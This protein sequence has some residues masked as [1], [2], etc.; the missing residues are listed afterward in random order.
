MKFFPLRMAMRELRRGKR[1]FIFFVLC[2]AIGVAGLV[3]VKGFNASIQEAMLQ[4]ARPLMAADMTL[5]TGRTITPEQDQF[6]AATAAERGIQV[7]RVTE[8]TSMALTADKQSFRLVEV[9]AVELGYPFY[10]N[11]EVEPPGARLT[12]DTAWVGADLLDQLGLQVG[13]Q[14]SVGRA[15]FTISGLIL[16][17]PDRVTAGFSMGPRVMITAGG[18]AKA[19]LIQLGSRARFKYLFKLADDTQVEQLRADLK[20]AFKEQRPSIADFREANPQVKRFL[21]RMTDFLSLV[22]LVALLVGGLGVANATRAFLQQKLDSIAIMKCVGGTNRKILLIYLTQMLLLSL[23]GSALGVLLGYT[24]QLVM[25]QVVGPIVNLTIELHLQPIVALQGLA[26]GLVTSV[27]FTLLPLSAIADI[28]PGLV[29]RREMAE[30]RPAP[31]AARRIRTAALLGAIGLGLVLV[32]AWMS[33]SLKWGLWFM[34]GLAGSVLLLLGAAWLVVRSLKLIRVPRAWISVR[35]GLAS[36]YRPGSQA[37]AIVL[38]LGIGI[39]MVLAVYLLQKGL[40]NEVSITVPKGAPNMVFINLQ[41]PDAEAFHA[42]LQQHPGVA[43]A[44]APTAIV[45]G[46]LVTIDGKTRDEMNLSEEEARWFNFQ[47]QTTYTRAIPEGDIVIEGPWWTEA[48]W[49]KEPLVSIEREA[50]ERLHMTVGSVVEMDLEGGTPI[51]ARVFNIRKTTDY[52]AGGG[53]NFVFAPGVLEQNG[54]ITY[55]AQASVR[56][57][58]SRDVQRAVVARF[59]G[60]T[61]I[62]VA[63]MLATVTEM[64]DRI[65]LVIRFVAGFSVLAGLLILASSIATTKYRRTREAVLYKTL[66]ATRARV[67]RIF[68]VEYAAL[69]LIAGFVSAFLAAVATW[70]VMKY[71]MEIDYV[72]DVRSLAVGVLISLVLTIAVGVLSTIDVLAAKP[73]QVLREE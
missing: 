43:K 2:I 68:A 33:G 59:P 16:K 25:P 67:W 38:A 57:G 70:G 18:L 23:A 22:S 51:R 47:F 41:A 30:S 53:F 6:I 11:L 26:V 9:K 31:T 62:D 50:A 54:R 13:D 58:A 34:G 65:S 71:V 37:G 1:K 56:P 14:I 17:E 49:T 42:L 24:V 46:R 4:E 27:L 55:Y 52:R 72:P 8:T 29:F 48:D 36:L 10:G 61:V 20:E 40:M 66:G 45:R 64:L 7:A 44:P 3:G 39:T 21:D 28:K 63:D 5:S 73:L 69:G 32:S 19:E 15:M 60:V 12:D 35:Q